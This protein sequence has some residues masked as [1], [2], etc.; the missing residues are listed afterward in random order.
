MKNIDLTKYGITGTTEVVYNPSYE[1]LFEEETNHQYQ[2]EWEKWVTTPGYPIKVN[3]YNSKLI[4]EAETLGDSFINGTAKSD[5]INQFKE[6]HT[7]QK[8]VFFNY[9]LNNVSKV[10]EKVYTDLRDI[11]KLHNNYNSEIKNL[12]YLLC[13]TTKHEDCIEHLKPFLQSFGRMK[14]IKPL[15]FEWFK[16]Q[17]EQAKKFFNDNKYLYHPVASRLIS[18]KFEQMKK[19]K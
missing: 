11:L 9:L 2:V 4:K 16:Y 7:N 1:M 13:L 18:E 6:W 10:S 5:V 14:Y 12:W 15:Y 17:P 19:E 3:T 8:I